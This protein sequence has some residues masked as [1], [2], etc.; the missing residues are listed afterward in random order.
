MK[1]LV[2]L[3]L[4]LALVLLCVGAAFAEGSTITVVND[5]PR[6]SIEGKEYKAYKILITIT[7]AH[8]TSYPTLKE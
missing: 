5:N 1:K 3:V 8:S 2:S 4:A 7:E 6:V